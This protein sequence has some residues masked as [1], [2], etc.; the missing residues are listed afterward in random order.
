MVEEA[1]RVVA[2]RRRHGE[3]LVAGD[4]QREMGE[5]RPVTR[6]RVL[7]VVDGHAIEDA[8]QPAAHVGDVVEHPRVQVHGG[9]V[10]L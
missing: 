2:D 9:T 7:P 4:V 10:T 6:R 5:R 1:G 8:L 3:V